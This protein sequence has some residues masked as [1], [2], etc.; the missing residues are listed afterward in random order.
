MSVQAREQNQHIIQTQKAEYPPSSLTIPRVLGHKILDVL[1][2]MKS[3]NII[4]ME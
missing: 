3:S 1:V 2:L 4:L